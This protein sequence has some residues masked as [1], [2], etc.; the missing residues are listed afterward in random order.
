MSLY[1]EFIM[2][3]KESGLRIQ[4]LNTTC[5]FMSLQFT[6]VLTK[7]LCPLKQVCYH[8]HYSFIYLVGVL[9]LLNSFTSTNRK[10]ATILPCLFF[11]SH[12][13]DS[14]T[15]INLFSNTKI[16]FMCLFKTTKLNAILY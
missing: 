11:S 6:S 14:G 10:G 1:S 9:P 5:L 2:W 13:R 7:S 3:D 4:A 8:F 16:H 15:E 12:C